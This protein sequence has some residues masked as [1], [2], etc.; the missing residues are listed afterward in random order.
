VS[1]ARTLERYRLPVGVREKLEELRALSRAAEGG[2]REARRELKRAL[3]RSAPEVV[4]RASDIGRRAQHALIGTA[5]GGDPLTEYALSG[6]LDMMREEIAGENPTPLET[7]LIERVVAC[8]LLVELFEVLMAAQLF[9]D[10]PKERR[11]PLGVLKHYL[12]WQEAANRRF[13]GSVRELA[14]L[15]KVQSSTP[16]VR[17]N[18][19][20]INLAGSGRR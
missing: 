11:V 18:N 12:A 13:L 2:D 5:A 6:R 17:V 1:E 16:G 10:T 8:W 4:A 15:R 9:P 19:V 14:R 20:Q 3:R 7:L